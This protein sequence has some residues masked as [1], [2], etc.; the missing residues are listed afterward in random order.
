M[1]DEDLTDM[2]FR[3]LQEKADRGDEAAKRLLDMLRKEP[4]EQPE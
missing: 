3:Q 2:V 4:D 1:D